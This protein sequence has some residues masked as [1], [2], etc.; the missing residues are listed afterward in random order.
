MNPDGSGKHVLLTLDATV[1]RAPYEPSRTTHVGARWF[2]TLR[3]VAGTYPS[4]EPRFELFALRHDGVLVQLTDGL[5]IQPA[6]MPPE[7][8]QSGYGVRPASPRWLTVGGVKDAMIS[9]VGRQW[10]VDATW[11]HGILVCPVDWDAVALKAQDPGA[12]PAAD[13]PAL[14]V[15]LPNEYYANLSGFDWSPDLGSVAFCASQTLWVIDTSDP[16]FTP[17]ALLTDN[18]LGQPRW[19]PVQPQGGTQI[20][21]IADTWRDCK[22]QVI[23][24]DGS[25]LRTLVAGNNS[26]N[27]NYPVLWSPHG[28]H[29]TYEMDVDGLG[30]NYCFVYRVSVDGSGNTA[31]T[32]KSESAAWPVGWSE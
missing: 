14:A 4:G 29:L 28:T 21:F 31:L 20:A 5:D 10:N 19:S 12:P 11:Q 23:N 22:V 3:Q 16:T 24:P 25:G 9:F 30:G 17:Q 13:A 6:M 8:Y 26:K 2:L 15:P 32:S 27:P 1:A 18:W 7:Y